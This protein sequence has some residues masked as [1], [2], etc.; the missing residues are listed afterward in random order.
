MT[1]PGIETVRA[2]IDALD[3]Q[4]V[5]LIAQ[6]QRWVTEAGRLKSDADAVRAPD[7]VEKVIQKIRT[8]AEQS[9][10][11]PDVVERTY[12][13]MIGA[14]VDLELQVHADSRRPSA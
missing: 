10:A 14:F 6:R 1:T 8:L 11:A 13:A 7:R 4:I 5:D 12:R 3:R 9:G 2:E